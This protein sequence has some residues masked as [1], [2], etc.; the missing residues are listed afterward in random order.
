LR[1]AFG[2]LGISIKSNAIAGI[3]RMRG[4]NLSLVSL[5]ALLLCSC[6]TPTQF[7]GSAPAAVVYAK[8]DKH[9][10]AIANQF[11]QL[12]MADAYKR[13]YW[14]QQRMMEPHGNQT[15]QTELRRDYYNFPV[16]EHVDK[17]GNVIEASTQ[18]V[19]IVRIYEAVPQKHRRTLFICK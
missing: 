5:C 17:D 12:A 15:N 4:K 9:D 11:T 2:G 7:S 18:S 1:L 8:L 16:P 13:L 3:K 14:A 10:K 6:G 19:E